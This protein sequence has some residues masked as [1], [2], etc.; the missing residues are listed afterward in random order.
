MGAPR[1]SGKLSQRYLTSAAFFVYLLSTLFVLECLHPWPHAGGNKLCCHSL[2][3]LVVTLSSPQT[4]P[5]SGSVFS[6]LW[7]DS[8]DSRDE[9][10][11]G[12]VC[13][14]DIGNSFTH[15][16]CCCCLKSWLHVDTLIF[17]LDPFSSYLHQTKPLSPSSF[18]SSSTIS[19]QEIV[20]DMK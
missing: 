5:I 10:R 1:P 20:R 8:D 2:S 7:A 15:F 12:K 13:M 17:F 11:Q 9:K 6:N 14:H 16:H 3:L 18:T 19:H 4:S